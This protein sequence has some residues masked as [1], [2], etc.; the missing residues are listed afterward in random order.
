MSNNSQGQAG[1]KGTNMDA[2]PQTF[3]WAE[4]ET[5]EGWKPKTPK[6]HF[7]AP[8]FWVRAGAFVIDYYLCVFL[9]YGIMTAS[10]FLL[11][12]WGIFDFDSLDDYEF[13]ITVIVCMY[14]ILLLYFF[15]VQGLWGRTAGKV[16]INA[17][18]VT[19]AGGRITFSRSLRRTAGYLASLFL[20]GVGF[21]VVAFNRNKTG[22]HDWIGGTQVV[23]RGYTSL[24]RKTA[25]IAAG[26]LGAAFM[27]YLVLGY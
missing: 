22:L 13:D 9:H 15:I 26:W 20:F 27:I 2:E 19:T 17:K 8:G 23:Y 18:I 21:L 3:E 4:E 16:L 5:G 1:N 7:D 11:R 14:I 24:W 12:E 25:A 6:P 10:D